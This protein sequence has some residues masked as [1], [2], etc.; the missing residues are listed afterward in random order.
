MRTL[1]RS[2]A[3]T[4]A[5]V[6]SAAAVSA[7]TTSKANGSGVPDGFAGQ[8]LSQFN[9]SMSKLVALAEATP[10]DKFAWS[11]GPGVM[12]VAKVHAHIAHYNYRYPSRAMGVGLPASIGLDTLESVASKAAVVQ[13]LKQS[14]DYVRAAVA[15]LSEA[16][17]AAPTRLYGQDVQ[18]WAVLFQ[19]LA[20]MNEHLGQSIAYARM[21]AIVPPWSQ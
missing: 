2:L 9:N 1:Q 14:G 7:Q 6:L 15:G 19:L 16:Q 3:A 17:L 4:L 10:A 11:P 8:F 20:H 18:K 5:V 13:L 21:N 12:S